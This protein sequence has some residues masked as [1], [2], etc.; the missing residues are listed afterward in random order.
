[1]RR[2]AEERRRSL[3]SPVEFWTEAAALIDWEVFPSTVLDTS[4]AP[5]YS[6]FPDGRLNTCFNALDRHVAA[7][8]GE[9]IAIIHDRPVTGTVTTLTY[10]ALLKR[11]AQFA[12]VLR[13]QGV[14]VG[15]RVLIYMPMVPE[16]AIAMLACARLGAVHSVVFG[17]FAAPDHL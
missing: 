7:G 3:E 16:A 10:A 4:N 15:D 2:H 1:M 17:G 12:G 6:W 13:E 8:H 9:R 14:G 5:L 11:V